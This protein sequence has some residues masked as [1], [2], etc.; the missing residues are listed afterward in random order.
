MCTQNISGKAPLCIV[1][2][3]IYIAAAENGN[4]VVNDKKE[5]ITQH[6]IAKEVGVTEVSIRN[7]AIDI[8]KYMHVHND[9]PLLKRKDE[10]VK[11]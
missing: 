10:E 5:K 6:M 7:R 8:C 11:K 9:W 3:S 4:L 2:A 1:G